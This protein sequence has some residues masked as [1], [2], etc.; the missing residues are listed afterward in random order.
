MPDLSHLD[1]LQA[2]L[3]SE[4]ASLRAATSQ[5]GR[6]IRTVWIAQ[7]EREIEDEYRFLGIDPTLPA[8]IAAMT[9]DGSG[10]RTWRSMC[11]ELRAELGMEVRGCKNDWKGA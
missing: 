11:D 10:W 6:K 8:D 5:F 4:R 7:I 9:R 2:R 1:A 3:R